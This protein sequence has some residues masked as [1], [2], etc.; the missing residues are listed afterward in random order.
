MT[1]EPIKVPRAGES[2]TEVTVNRWLKPDGAF[3]KADD[4]LVEL[5]T[6]KATQELAAPAAG[7]LRHRAKEGDTVAVDAV[8]AEIDTS[9]K[10]PAE[11][12]APTGRALTLPARPDPPPAPRRP[13]RPG[14]WPRRASS[15]L[16]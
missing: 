15:R 2:I 4:P 13:P 12:P 5:G 8:I 9:A 1:V 14:C 11:K 16:T 7:V 6:D 10:A 3:V